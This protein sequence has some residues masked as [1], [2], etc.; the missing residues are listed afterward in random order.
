MRIIF[1][2]SSEFAV[3]V[4]DALK[5]KQE[6]VLVVTQP[7]RKKGRSL[8]IS[9]TPVKTAAKSSG[10]KIFQPDNV[11]TQD[12]LEYLKKLGAD[13]FVVVS[14]GQILR[15]QLLDIPRIYPVNVHASLLPK[16]RGAAPVNWALANGEKETGVTIIRMNE[17][18]DEGE[19]ILKDPVLIED[20]EDA[21]TLSEKLSKKG[22]ELLLNAIDLIEKNTVS[23]I[24]QDDKVATYAPK[25]K[26]QD[27]LIDW[28]LSAKGIYNRIR[29]FVPW[30]GCYACWNKKIFKIW[31]AR[32]DNNPVATK[33]K[34][35]AVLECSK[36]GISVGT[37]A[38]A[39]MIEELQLQGKRRMTAEEFLA[40]HKDLCPGA[41]FTS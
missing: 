24:K 11:N 18:M 7:D 15:S 10:I 33:P 1:F 14:F 19:I 12:S 13:L 40:G 20:G 30:P 34:P 26:K 16:Y 2:G 17:G 38:G 35:G 9:S 29:A 6:I 31:K 21:I 37:G 41:K 36:D 27:G 23:F 5:E 25:L 3:P 4:L 32:P 8:K 39:L 28:R 22:T